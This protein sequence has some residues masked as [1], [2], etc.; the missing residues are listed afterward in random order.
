MVHISCPG[1]PYCSVHVLGLPYISAE[2]TEGLFVSG[3][4]MSCNSPS[5]MEMFDP[6]QGVGLCFVL[7][8]FVCFFPFR[9]INSAPWFS[10]QCCPIA[11]IVN[12]I[13]NIS[14]ATST[15]MG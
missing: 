3:I 1:I 15:E 11:A 4:H 14:A 13:T 7:F 2:E 5:V 12:K 6:A 8:C 9:Y 10:E